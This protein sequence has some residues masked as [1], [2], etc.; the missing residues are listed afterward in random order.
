MGGNGGKESPGQERLRNFPAPT[1]D[2]GQLATC[3]VPRTHSND[4]TPVPRVSKLGFHVLIGFGI[5]YIK[6]ATNETWVTTG[7]KRPFSFKG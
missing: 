3:P 1:A 2:Y 4:V 6:Q 7:D 5:L